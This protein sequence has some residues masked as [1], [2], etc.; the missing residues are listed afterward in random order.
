LRNHPQGTERVGSDKTR[1]F[2]ISFFVYFYFF[3]LLSSFPTEEIRMGNH[4]PAEEF[5][6]LGLEYKGTGKVL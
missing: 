4:S 1:R 5:R 2:P 6:A 3:Y